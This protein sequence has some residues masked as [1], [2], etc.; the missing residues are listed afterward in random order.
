MKVTNFEI[1]IKEHKGGF[2]TVEQVF[3][4]WPHKVVGNMNTMIEKDYL[5]QFRFETQRGVLTEH[6]IYLAESVQQGLDYLKETYPAI[7]E[8][9]PEFDVA[10]LTQ[11]GER[12][13]CETIL[14]YNAWL[15]GEREDE[16]IDIFIEQMD[17]NSD[18]D[19]VCGDYSSLE[20]LYA[21]IREKRVIMELQCY[22][23]TSNG[24]W[25]YFCTEAKPLIDI[26]EERS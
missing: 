14:R 6:V 8:Q 25:N 15:E 21:G 19:D 23:N 7:A 12:A 3:D 24:F 10:K 16:D 9:V 22:P 2:E 13:K 5:V 17:W 20:E 1:T 4:S 18:D 26:I 11:L